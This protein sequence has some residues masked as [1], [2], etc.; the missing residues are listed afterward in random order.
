MVPWAA[1]VPEVAPEA[2]RPVDVSS[3]AAAA[4]GVA[5]RRDVSGSDPFGTT[6]QT[7][8]SSSWRTGKYPGGQLFTQ[9]T[10]APPSTT[11]YSSGAQGLRPTERTAV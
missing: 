6:K 9:A 2:A 5:D 1:V 11:K 8:P 10:P 4:S 7:G 3:A